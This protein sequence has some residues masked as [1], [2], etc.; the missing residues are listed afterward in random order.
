MII[1]SLSYFKYAASYPNEIACLIA[2]DAIPQINKPKENF[3]RIQG[4]RVDNSLQ[5]HQKPPRNFEVDLTFEKA[6]E[7]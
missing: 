5:Y 3:F 1:F 6:Y 4:D 7:L 2:I